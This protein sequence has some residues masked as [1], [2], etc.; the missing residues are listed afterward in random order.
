MGTSS[1]AEV[2]DPQAFVANMDSTSGPNTMRA[3]A[4][5]SRGGMFKSDGTEIKNPAA[6]VA[7]ITKYEGGLF[8]SACVEIRIPEAFV[9]GME[10][11]SSEPNKRPTSKMA[12]GY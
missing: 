3:G 2:R 5:S 4:A 9:A 12:A 8:T 1:G 11:S 10:G 6:F 7:K